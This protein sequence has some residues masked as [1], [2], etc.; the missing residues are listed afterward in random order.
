MRQKL[1][2][3]LFNRFPDLYREKDLPMTETAM[4]W[5]FDV[6]DGWWSLI[7]ALSATLVEIDPDI[8]ARQVKEKFGSLRFYTSGS[9]AAAL[10][11]ISV[12]EALSART[13]EATGRRGTVI[14]DGGWFRTLSPDEQ[15]EIPAEDGKDGV[16][17]PRPEAKTARTREEAIAILK[18]RHPAAL[19]DAKLLDFPAGLLDLIDVTLGA[20]RGRHNN[21]SGPVVRI[22]EISWN[23]D[24][25][26]VLRPSFAS[27]RA[28]ALASIEHERKSVEEHGLPYTPPPLRDIVVELADQVSGAAA[29]AR[30]MAWRMEVQTGR[31]GPVDDAGNIIDM[32]PLS[33]DEAPDRLANT[34]QMLKILR[35]FDPEDLTKPIVYTRRSAKIDLE[36]RRSLADGLRDGSWKIVAPKIYAGRNFASLPGALPTAYHVAAGLASQHHWQLMLPVEMSRFF[37]GRA[38]RPNAAELRTFYYSEPEARHYERLGLTLQPAPEMRAPRLNVAGQI[39]W[40]HLHQDNPPTDVELRADAS[41]AANAWFSNRLIANWLWAEVQADLLEEQERQLAEAILAIIAAGTGVADEA[42][43]GF[44]PAAHEA[45]AAR[46]YGWWIQ[47]ANDGTRTLAAM[48]IEGHPQIA[49][50]DRLASSTGIVWI[51]TAL[52]W[53]RTR[54]RYYRLMGGRFG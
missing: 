41:F 9:S 14:N 43:V 46:I 6:G 30:E 20:V 33:A 23:S 39:I 4:C 28:A 24:E 53:A 13:S 44:D 49:D 1:Q 50:G 18:Q 2:E 5:G 29:F 31:S 7:A 40:H 16:S 21:P 19:A 47:T 42:P 32:L 48:R 8:R 10:A 45:S 17:L 35:A 3:L 36:T 11:A 15:A 52:G 38:S 51:D 25:G 37:M 22:E 54:S 26:L 34:R 27:L 12:A